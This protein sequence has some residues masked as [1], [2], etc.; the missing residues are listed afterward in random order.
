L[1]F[2]DQSQ[3]QY[4]INSNTIGVV[5]G[6]AVPTNQWFYYALVYNGSAASVYA[7]SESS[8]A[9][10]IATTNNLPG[11]QLINFGA[12]GSLMVGNRL[13]LDRALD[14]W[15]QDFRFYTF[16]TNLSFVED[17]RWSALGPAS[18]TALP[19][20][21]QVNL[22]WSALAGAASYT[23][24]RSTTNGSGYRVLA[25]GITGTNYVDA[26]ALSGT[27]YYYVVSAVD[28]GGH[29]LA[30]QNS[31]SAGVTAPPPGLAAQYSA[32]NL[33]LSWPTSAAGFNLY[34]T[35]SLA[36]VINWLRVT[37]PPA[38]QGINATLDLPYDVS[39]RFFRLSQP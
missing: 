23:V 24:S 13:A 6:S 22:S 30:S 39:N 35:P 27:T 21:N 9:V 37:N 38:T 34:G 36:P 4:K 31:S 16:A 11:P 1:A 8:P 25:S 20:Y 18:L 32:T 14:G 10:L 28:V 2:F 5:Y 29:G 7:G 17:I 15:V 33:T 26:T 3:L 12:S 19:G